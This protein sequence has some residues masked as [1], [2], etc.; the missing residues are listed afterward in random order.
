M[1]LYWLKDKEMKKRF[2]L[3]MLGIGMMS[4][5]LSNAYPAAIAEESPVVQGFNEFAF[6]LYRQ[7]GKPEENMIISPY[8]LSSSLGLLT[9]GAS[10]GTLTQLMQVL[11]IED[12]Q[13][14]DSVNAEL[15]KLSRVINATP[16]CVGF[17]R[18]QFRKVKTWL[19]IGRPAQL[20]MQANA[21]WADQGFTYRPSF[22]ETMI[23]SK[24]VHFYRVDFM[25]APEKAREKMNT[26]VKNNT[27]GYI[28]DLIPKGEISTH[29][30]LVLTNALYFKGLWQLPFKKDETKVGPFTLTSGAKVQV[31]MMHK[32]DKFFYAENDDVQMLQLPYAKSTLSMA[33]VLPKAK[34]TVQDIQKTMTSKSFQQLLQESY[35]QEVIVSLPT[36]TLRSTFGEL[37]Q[38]LE[39]MGLKDAFNDKADFSAMTSDALAISGVIQKAMIEVDETGTVAAAATST[40]MMA[41]AYMPPINFE[42]D[43]AFIFII[44]D[45]ESTMILFMGQVENPLVS[46]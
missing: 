5:A 15:S 4:L 1:T 29:T 12:L 44:F 11:H 27:F 36:F 13:D 23:K 32:Q 42:A 7:V 14:G 34:R 38:A 31:P 37:N 17:L 33:I 28:Q 24:T 26:W 40:T 21:F 16:P 22:L 9:N 41:T 45:R 2:L 46:P 43:H 30:K 20:V 8:S 6:D 25:N 3:V 35:K 18:C 10:G 19:G 39:V